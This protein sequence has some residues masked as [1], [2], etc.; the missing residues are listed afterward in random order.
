MLVGVSKRWLALAGAGRRWL[1]LAGAGWCWLALAGAGAGS[2]AGAS[3]ASS[4]DVGATPGDSF[5]TGSL[6]PSSTLGS[7]IDDGCGPELEPRPVCEGEEPHASH[8]PGSSPP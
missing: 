4:D 1:A 5:H 6:S 3:A 7:P 8:L 2:G